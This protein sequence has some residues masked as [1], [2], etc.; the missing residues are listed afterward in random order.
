MESP[1]DCWGGRLLSA[2]T[3]SPPP[4]Q[5]GANC[6]PERNG[7]SDP[8]KQLFGVKGQRL[9]WPVDRLAAGQNKST[10]EGPRGE[11]LSG[12]P[13]PG[14]GGGGAGRGGGLYLPRRAPPGAAGRRAA[15]AAAAAR[16]PGASA[17]PWRWAGTWDRGPDGGASLREL[18]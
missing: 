15:A 13:A 12:M 8:G 16:A 17:A 3:H 4:P 5:P 18:G 7:V 2:E 10:G 11:G 1:Q 6:W 9:A 14:G